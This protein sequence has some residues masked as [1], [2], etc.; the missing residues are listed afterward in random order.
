MGDLDVL[1]P[2][3]NSQ[4][5]LCSQGMSVLENPNAWGRLYPEN[6]SL[7]IEDLVKDEYK[8]GR[9]TYGVDFQFTKEGFSVNVMNHIS[10]VH[11]IISRE[12]RD[13]NR[14][15]VFITDMSS[16]GTFLNGEKIGKN[17]RWVLSNNDKIAVIKKTNY[18]YSYIDNSAD[19]P[20][21][22]QEVRMELAVYGIL[23]TGTFGEVRIAFNKKTTKCFALKKVKRESCVDREHTI[24]ASLQHPNI[25]KMDKYFESNDAVYICLEYMPSGSLQ[26]LLMNVNN[27]KEDESKIILYQ[28]ARAIQYLHNRLIAHRDL[29]PA[30]ILLS[31][32]HAKLAD[33]GLSKIV[34]DNTH[35]KTFCGS[36]AYIAPEVFVNYKRYYKQA[37]AYTNKV[38]SWSF[39]VILYECLTGI[40]PFTGES[41]ELKIRHGAYEMTKS[42]FLNTS[43][44][45]KDLIKKL[46]M[47]DYSVRF[48][49]DQVI[50]HAWFDK[51]IKM[52]RIVSN[53][54]S[55]YTVVNKVAKKQLNEKENM[56][57]KLRF[58]SCVTH[59]T[60]SCST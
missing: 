8:A 28:V 44:G 3:I 37:Y 36:L 41:L 32:R 4:E 30:N 34:T 57:K 13:A 38:D 26:D 60:S 11:F 40:K 18:V 50:D 10:K 22:P 54:I 43:S 47:V 19:I 56:T 46:I 12:E 31:G 52:K 9:Q 55:E 7:K 33:F 53:L 49:F 27:L 51:D 48:N 16:N 17:C 58:C 45:A 29:K 21:L 24:L 5:P 2:L 42:L 25:V 23:G 59:T 15:M 14:H 6:E 1:T 20:N 39:G 35:L